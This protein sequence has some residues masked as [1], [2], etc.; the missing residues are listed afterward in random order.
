MLTTSND[1]LAERLRLLRGHGM[2]PRYYHQTVGINSRLDSIQ[3]A[4]LNVKLPHLATWAA[5]R[6]EN[7]ARYRQLFVDAQLER[8]LGLP[9]QQE[10][11]QHVWNQYTIRVAQGHRDA[12]REYLTVAGIGTEIYYPVPLHQQ[13]CFRDLS[14][15]PNQY[16]F[17]ETERAAEQVLS[18]PIFPGLFATEQQV[19]VARIADFFKS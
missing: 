5:Q 19:V 4:V 3:A 6:Q 10:G 8:V 18:L 9:E 1:A 13:E 15:G 12:L 11:Q 7:A 17:L 14:P 2:Q 16:D